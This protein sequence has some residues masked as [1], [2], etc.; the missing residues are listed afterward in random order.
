MLAP[1][2]DLAQDP[3]WGRTEETY[4]EDPYLNSRMGVAAITGFQGDHPPFIDRQH[5]AA[6]ARNR[7]ENP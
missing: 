6:M 1:V 5:V 7:D 4:G 3:R 2:L